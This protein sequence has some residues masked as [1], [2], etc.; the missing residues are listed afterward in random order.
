MKYLTLAAYVI[1]GTIAG[2]AAAAQQT[3]DDRL[4]AVAAAWVEKKRQAT[5]EP[6]VTV[7]TD[8]GDVDITALD[9]EPTENWFGK[10]PGFDTVDG[11]LEA[12]EKAAQA[13]NTEVCLEQLANVEEAISTSDER[14]GDK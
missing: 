10:P 3:C 7:S 14:S 6:D 2:Q 4:T 1:T 8:Q 11:Y 5:E 12:A 13:G 9:A